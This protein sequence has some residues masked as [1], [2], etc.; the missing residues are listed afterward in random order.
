MHNQIRLR[1]V[2]PDDIPKFF[3]YQLDQQANFMA[4]F[5]AKDPSDREAF[6]E[7]WQK[8]TSDKNIFIRT[9]IF[10][11]QIAGY[12]LSYETD[13]EPEVSYWLGKSYWGKG[14]ATKSLRIFLNEVNKKR[15]MY[16]RVAKDNIGSI[17]VLEKF[18]FKVLEQM[19][20]FAN[21]RG[22]EIEELKMVL[23]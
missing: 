18:G 13:G 9:I 16:A 7:H 12:V 10:S 17:R 14:I 4:A 15:P 11:E 20:G 22:K 21:A 1:S 3:E 19:R 6:D 23:K 2:L 8:I 5:T